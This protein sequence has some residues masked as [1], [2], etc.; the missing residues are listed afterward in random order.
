VASAGDP[1]QELRAALAET[2]TDERAETSERPASLEERR[3]RVHERA[4]EALDAM[5]D[6]PAGA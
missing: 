2:E 5:K 3:Q 1:A 4:Q 6:P